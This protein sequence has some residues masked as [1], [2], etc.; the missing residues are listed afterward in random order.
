VQAESL[1]HQKWAK[2]KMRKASRDRLY[3]RRGKDGLFC[4]RYKD[5]DGAWREKS[6]GTADRTEAK[7]FKQ[8]FDS[9]LE[10][11][12]LP[13]DKAQWSVEQAATRWVEQHAARLGS[14]K[15]KR[16]E[17]SLLNKLVE[18]L[19][20][21]KL[22]S[23]TLDDLKDYQRQRRQN[24]G[25]RAVNLEL[26]VL[27]NVLKEGNLWRPFEEHFKP[28]VEPESDIGQALTVEELDLLEKTAATKDDWQVAYCSEVLSANTG[29]RS[30]EVK[31]LQLDAVD[32]ENRRLQI[33]RKGTKSN[34]G[35]R[36]VELNHAA[37]AAVAKLYVRARDLGA[38]EPIHYLLP[39][40]LSRHTHDGDP[41]KGKRGFD[42][43]LP[44][45]S[46]RTAWRS[47]RDA[48]AK[49]VE[50]QAAQ[51]RP[52]LTTEERKRIAMFKR[53]RF[54]DLRHSFISLMAERGVPLQVCMAM[55]GHLSAKMVRYYTHISNRAARQAVELLDKQS[56]TAAFVDKFVDR[57]ES[58]RPVVA[59]SLN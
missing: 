9:D 12:T 43:N 45:A 7:K 20:T 52:D 15:A 50:D 1:P 35:Q 55:V 37:T 46:W 34:A 10:A 22:K 27:Q 3:R 17:R 25:P 26:R 40:D 57:S 21:R 31:R 2:E 14:A 51:E 29:L 23:I 16:N 6:T 39:A 53:L 8:Q 4:F 33:R 56:E 28:L 13:T 38:I 42:V 5:K 32:L 36:L 58:R 11:G 47:L 30:I 24:V 44:Q 59:K 48:A 49:M 41:L 54:H 18:R 19:G